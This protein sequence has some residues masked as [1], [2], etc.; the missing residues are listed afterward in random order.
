[1]KR[2][3]HILKFLRSSSSQ[4]PLKRPGHILKFLRASSSQAPSKAT[5]APSL[6]KRYTDA[7]SENPFRVKLV[8]AAFIF[9]TGDVATQVAE[10]TILRND[11]SPRESKEAGIRD[12]KQG[13]ISIKISRTAELAF[14]GMLATTCIHFW[15]GVLEPL[16]IRAFDPLT[17]KFRHVLFKVA[18]DQSLGATCYNSIFF[19][20][21]GVAGSMQGNESVV[22]C[23][24][25]Q[26][27]RNFWPQLQTHWTFWPFFHFLNFWFNP[28]HQRVV[29]QN[30][31]SIGWGVVL[32]RVGERNR[33]KEERAGVGVGFV[34][35]ES[36]KNVCLR[37]K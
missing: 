30:F 33:R 19:T 5:P 4:A 21:Q 36:S 12:S 13:D 14:F 2:P 34:V 29:W 8:T 35:D 31:A 25:H 6:I 28:L 37:G 10:Q 24:K 17:Q 1:M 32:S 26:L 27:G 18:L 23:V 20:V 3:G 16:A 11:I 9:T 22:D 15:W 7:L